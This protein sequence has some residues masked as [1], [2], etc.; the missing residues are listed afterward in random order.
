[1]KYEGPL[2]RGNDVK[3]DITILERFVYPLQQRPVLRGYEKFT[4]IPEN[5]PVQVYALEEIVAEKT[6]A[7]ADRARN[8]PRDL[9]DLWY[10]TS[11]TDVGIDH[12]AEAIRQELEFRGAPCERIEDAIIRKEAR[13]K[14]LWSSRL[15]YQMTKLP[16][17]DEVFRMTRRALRQAHLP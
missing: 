9:Y 6:L 17:F 11:K 5:C 14:A 13:L 16:S 7:L 1:M 12:L 8:E 2:P 15:A 4:D 3:V 10:L